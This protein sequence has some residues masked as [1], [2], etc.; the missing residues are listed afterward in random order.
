[1]KQFHFTYH[2]LSTTTIAAMMISTKSVFIA[3]TTIAPWLLVSVNGMAELTQEMM[4]ARNLQELLT[5]EREHRQLKDQ[6]RNMRSR[7]LQDQGLVDSEHVLADMYDGVQ[8]FYHGVASG[9][10]R[11]LGPCVCFLSA[12]YAIFHR[13]VS[14]TTSP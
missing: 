3:I 9:K 12:S 1:M 14:N 8:G 6:G 7:K 5:A 2:I 10:R 11:D 13:T 4:Q